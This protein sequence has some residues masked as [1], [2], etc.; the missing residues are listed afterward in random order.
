MKSYVSIACGV[1]LAACG[2][3][4]QKSDGLAF[5]ES[6][7]LSIA[8]IDAVGTALEAF[9]TEI[10]AETINGVQRTDLIAQGSATYTG[11]MISDHQTEDV[12]ILGRATVNAVFSGGGSVTGAIDE[13]VHI[14]ASISGG[15][16]LT[17]LADLE[18]FSAA[19]LPSDATATP[20]PGLLTLSDGDLRE[21]DDGTASIYILAIGSW[22]LDETLSSTGN[23]EV[24]DVAGDFGSGVG[25][26]GTL[27]GTGEL[28][29][30]SSDTGFDVD[31]VLFARENQ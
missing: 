31:A 25:T 19:A 1:M 8:E 27:I 28:Q 21:D 17:D 5:T 6:G 16:P 14:D 13:L 11:Y 9:G 3:T 18:A 12:S 2:G 30:E 26:D 10:G 22:T 4:T 29:A 7:P 23:V 20:I 15:A 24:F